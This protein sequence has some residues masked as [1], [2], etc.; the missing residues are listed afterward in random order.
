MRA[1]RWSLLVVVGTLLAACSSGS[2]E[3]KSVASE[4]PPAVETPAM[5]APETA[6][7]V[8]EAV[9]PA[10]AQPL[11]PAAASAP[12]PLDKAAAA[13]LD[14][15]DDPLPEGTVRKAPARPVT[16]APAGGVQTAAAARTSGA[17]Q[18]TGRLEIPAIGVNHVTYEGIDLA[19]IN[20]GPSHWPGT[21]MPGQRGNTVFPG[22]RTTYSRPFWDLDR[23]RPGNEVIFSNPTGR[24]TYQVTHTLIVSSTDTYVVNNTP[25]ATFTLMACHP[26]GSARQR[27]VVKGRLV[28]APLAPAPPPPSS[29]PGTPP[30]PPERSKF[31]G[32][33]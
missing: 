26:K 24:F 29:S 27:I 13:A 19:T 18:P 17:P 28:S 20:Y 14:A 15:A 4:P 2:T 33:L 22:H 31:L 16:P 32:I 7:A 30:R 11:V 21:P 1:S 10:V 6:P 3:V 23:L 12:A 25:D 8:P 9:E 5:P